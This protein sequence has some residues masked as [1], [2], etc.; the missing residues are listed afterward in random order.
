MTIARSPPDAAARAARSSW[1]PA[2][3]T[4]VLLLLE[5]LELELLPQ[6][7]MNAASEVAA[8][9]EP[10]PRAGHLQEPLARHIVAR[11]LEDCALCRLIR[12]GGRFAHGI[13]FRNAQGLV[14]GFVPPLRP[15]RRMDHRGRVDPPES[16]RRR[17]R[18]ETTSHIRSGSARGCAHRRRM[19]RQQHAFREHQRRGASRP[20]PPRPPRRPA[21]AA[22][23]VNIANYALRPAA[24]DGQ[25]GHEGDVRQPRRHRAHCHR[26]RLPRRS[27]P[28]RSSRDGTATVTLTKPGTYSYICQFHPFMKATITVG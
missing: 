8:A 9:A 15:R 20:R 5:L 4:R 14:L 1:W 27:T 26:Q 7:A 24:A 18:H 10:M 23:T 11:Q 13:S 3:P 2:P 21:P 19:R 16:R 6:A 25:G 17:V 28:A 22:T 12:R